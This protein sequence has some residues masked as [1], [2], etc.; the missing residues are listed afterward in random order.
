MEQKEKVC[1]KCE[2]SKPLSSFFTRRN[3]KTGKAYTQSYCKECK[4]SC[5]SGARAKKRVESPPATP[6]ERMTPEVKQR[7]SI[8]MKAWYAANPDSHPWKQKGRKYRFSAPCEKLKEYLRSKGIEFV[9]EFPPNV[10][11]RNFSLDI[12]LPEKKIAIEVNGTQHYNK[13]GTLKPYYQER[14][15][16][17]ERNGWTVYELFYS[18]CYQLKKLES[19]IPQMLS[20]DK[21]MEFDYR[22]YVPPVKVPKTCK[23]GKVIRNE[24][25]KCRS[26]DSERRISEALILEDGEVAGLLLR[27]K[28]RI[29]KTELL[30]TL[31]QNSYV[32]TG[33]IYGVTDNSVRKWCRRLGIP[34]R[35]KKQE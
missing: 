31:E 5:Q 30:K 24:S 11:G 9:E 27:G 20:G 18:V 23:C 17:L 7:I 26:C 28:E 2:I 4:A 32:E 25:L 12:A 33:K 29:L 16:I 22:T 14:H 13:D 10:E 15:D 19:M 8:K 1:A 6:K 3:K 34:I 21:K 35:K